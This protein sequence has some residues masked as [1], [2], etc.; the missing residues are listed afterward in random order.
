MTLQEVMQEL[1]SYANKGTKR[2]YKNHGAREPLFGVKVGDM[3]KILK[4]TKENHELALQLY[5]TGN[6]DAMYLAGLMADPN[7]ATKDQLNAWVKKAYW[8]F[9]SEYAVAGLAAESPR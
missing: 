5:T 8:Y 4:K 3:K 1:E 7:Q 9:L 6:S 2:V